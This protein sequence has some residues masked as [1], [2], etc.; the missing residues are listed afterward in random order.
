MEG[1]ACYATGACQPYVP[2][3]NA[4]AITRPIHTYSHA[5]GCAVIGGCVYRG[6]AIPDL[7]GTYFFGDY[8]TASIWSFRYTGGNLTQFRDRTAELA[9]G[10]GLSLDNPTHFGEDARGEIHILDLDGEVLKIVSRAPVPAVDL[11]FGK[12]GSNRLIPTFDA[13]GILNTGNA[14]ELRLRFAPA[15]AAAVLCLSFSN[16]P[17]PIFNG[18]LVPVPIDVAVV[19]A[20]GPSGGAAFLAPGGAGPFTLYAQ[21]LVADPGLPE[22]VGISNA[23]RIDFLP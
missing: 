12:P 13:C 2:S 1:N 14:A 8:C 7:R 3:C 9:P 4:P 15:N 5:L 23:L 18:T 11:G 19:L 22:L 20:C 16:N 21:F 6:C 10:G 17:T